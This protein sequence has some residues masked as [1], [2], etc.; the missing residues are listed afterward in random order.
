MPI[1]AAL[2]WIVSGISALGG[3]FGNRKNTQQQTQQNQS[4]GL[5]YGSTNVTPTYDPAN[6]ILRDKVIGGYEDLLNEDPDLSGYSTQGFQNIQQASDARSRSLQNILASRGINNAPASLFARIQ[7]ESGRLSDAAS[8]YN[9]LPLLRRQ[10]REETLGRA[11]QFQ[12]SIPTG[13]SSNF[14]TTSSGESSG[15]G[16]STDPGNLLGGGLGGLGSALAFLLGRGAFGQLPG[17]K[18]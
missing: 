8:F 1:S 7:N 9:Q 5:Q 18:N 16:T 6:N 15:T 2:P 13:T 3:L 11:G 14:S 10:L 4:T 12:A 17:G